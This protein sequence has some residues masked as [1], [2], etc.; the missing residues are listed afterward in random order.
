[1]T[2]KKLGD[3]WG[4]ITSLA[5]TP[6]E[7]FTS[8]K[9][10]GGGKCPPVMAHD[11]AMIPGLLWIFLHGCKVKYGSGLGTRLQGKCSQAFSLCFCILYM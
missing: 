4:G 6:H 2:V 10:R 9:G 8:S 3:G 5:L 11:V 7:V 1:M